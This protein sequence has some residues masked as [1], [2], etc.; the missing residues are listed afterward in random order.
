[1]KKSGKQSTN[2][3]SFSK[4]TIIDLSIS[5]KKNVI[6]GGGEEVTLRP[7]QDP[8]KRKTHPD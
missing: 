2:G 7:T 6:G 4:E 8:Q 3:L 5:Q 1:M